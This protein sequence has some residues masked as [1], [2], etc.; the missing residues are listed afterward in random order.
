M[1]ELRSTEALDT[2]IRNDARRKAGKILEQAEENAGT[3]LADVEKK[4]HEAAEAARQSSRNRLAL[5]EKNINASLPLEKERHLVS[6]IHNAVIEAMNAYFDGLSAGQRLD[7]IKALVERSQPVLFGADVHAVAVGI[8]VKAAEKMLRKELGTSVLSCTAGDAQLLADEAVP[9]F[10][11]REG[12]ILRSA[13]GRL[14]CRLSL[15]EKVKEILDTQRAE[16]AATLFCGRL[17]E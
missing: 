2:E 5:Y 14:V 9:G 7:I 3:L 12:I 11:R 8:D 10:S 4:V 17:P 13:D 1:E 15:D 6:Y 16:L